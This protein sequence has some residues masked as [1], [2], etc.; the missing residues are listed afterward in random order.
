MAKFP[1]DGSAP[2]PLIPRPIEF[3]VRRMPTKSDPRQTDP[4]DDVSARL[5][6]ARNGF[7]FSSWVSK[8]Q[9]AATPALI[10]AFKSIIFK[11][12]SIILNTKFVDLNTNGHHGDVR[13]VLDHL[14]SFERSINRRHVYTKQ[15]EIYQS[16]ACIYKADSIQHTWETQNKLNTRN[17]RF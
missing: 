3:M 16:P 2:L 15:S 11:T 12:K 10:F 8:Y 17:T 13:D 14:Q 9:A 1:P 4:K 6:L 5:M 7:S